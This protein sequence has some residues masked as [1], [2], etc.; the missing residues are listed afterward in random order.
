[1]NLKKMNVKE[2]LSRINSTLISFIRCMNIIRKQQENDFECYFKRRKIASKKGGRFKR[3]I[4][5]KRGNNKR[6]LELEEEQEYKLKKRE[7][8]KACLN[9]TH[10][11]CMNFFETRKSFWNTNAPTYEEWISDFH[12]DNVV[13]SPSS[14]KLFRRKSCYIIDHRFYLRDSDHRIIWNGY[15]DLYG[16]TDQKVDYQ[17]NPLATGGPYSKTKRRRSCTFSL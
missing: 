13:H 10:K 16:C 15:C 4:G 8:I 5:R 14:R 7:S 11:H 17:N 9:E 6:M 3:A 1:M 2:V 12:P